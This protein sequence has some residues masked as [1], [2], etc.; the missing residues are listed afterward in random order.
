VAFKVEAGTGS[1]FLTCEI[2][3]VGWVAGLNIEW[4]SM[5]GLG[6]YKRLRCLF[7]GEW[8]S[9]LGGDRVRLPNLRDDSS[10]VAGLKIEWLSRLGLGG[11]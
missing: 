8:L 6:G 9:I 2:T 11:Y 3:Q 4:L 5:L 1:A 10:W 7:V